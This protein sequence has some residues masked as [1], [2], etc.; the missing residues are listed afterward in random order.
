MRYMIE[1]V[2]P[3]FRQ[4]LFMSDTEERPFDR[5]VRSAVYRKAKG[6]DSSSAFGS[7][8]EFDRNEIKLRHSMFPLQKSM[9]QPLSAKLR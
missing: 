4:Y 5:T 9:L 2:G 8:L 3:E 6:V 7:Q 1:S